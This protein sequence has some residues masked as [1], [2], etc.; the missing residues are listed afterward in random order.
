MKALR[1]VARV[2]QRARQAVGAMLGAN[3]DQH[4]AGVL[5][6]QRQQ[7]RRLVRALDEVDILGGLAGRRRQPADRRVGPCEDG[8][9]RESGA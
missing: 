6:D 1:R 9:V 8:I 3:E 5:L 2:A 7:Q 4:G